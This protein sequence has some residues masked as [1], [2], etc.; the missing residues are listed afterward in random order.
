M[1]VGAVSCGIHL[2]TFNAE[3]S[4]AF[5]ALACIV[6]AAHRTIIQPINTRVA[7]AIAELASGAFSCAVHFRAVHTYAGRALATL[8]R[9]AAGAD[10]ATVHAGFAG[11]GPAIAELAAGAL[12]R[13][14]WGQA[15]PADAIALATPAGL[16]AGTHLTSVLE[17]LAGVGPAVTVAV[18]AT[19]FTRVNSRALGADSQGRAVAGLAGVVVQA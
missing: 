6:G 11:E 8:A 2:P 17:G 10:A 3:P 16:G 14:V 19:L 5:S 12:T 18:A 4:P 13:G 15:L 1:A 7:P 9:I